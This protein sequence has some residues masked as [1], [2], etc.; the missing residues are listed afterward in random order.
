M[1]NEVA[2]T[3]LASMLNVNKETV[4]RYVDL[5][6]KSYIIFRLSPFSRNLRNELKKMR[7]IYFYDNG[8][9]NALINNYNPLL[10]RNDVG[11]LWENFIISERRKWTDSIEL[12]TNRYFWR[13]HQKREVDYLEEYGGDIHAYEIKWNKYKKPAKVFVD[14]YFPKT[15]ECINKENY[16]SLLGL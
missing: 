13:N 3:E 6:E 1:G 7:K 5:L 8:V 2:F 16:Y 11:A 12:H 14:A 10:L 9:R 4:E 15:I